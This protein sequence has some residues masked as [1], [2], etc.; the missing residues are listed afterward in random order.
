[1]SSE[2]IRMFRVYELPGSNMEHLILSFW[3]SKLRE[4][5]ENITA[6]DQGTKLF[7]G[8][9]SPE[10]LAA[11][12][13]ASRLS[14]PAVREALWDGGLDAA[15]ASN[16]PLIKRASQRIAQAQFANY[17]TSVYPDATFSLRL[18]FGK[19]RGWTEN[20][21]A[22]PTFTHFAGL[23][24]SAT[25]QYPFALT[26][27]RLVRQICARSAFALRC[28]YGQQHSRWQFW[29]TDH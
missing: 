27:K 28:C 5:R 21:V 24:G 10:T 22:V 14:H 19:V 20:E 7:P 6:D 1:M 3:G 25:G 29:I 4:N 16:H 17:G 13:V 2:I 23:Y 9:E 12:V 15:K 11:R 18:S 8:K 26:Q